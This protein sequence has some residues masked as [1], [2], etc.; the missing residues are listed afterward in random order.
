MLES[1]EQLFECKLRPL[2]LFPMTLDQRPPPGA[3]ADE[4]YGAERHEQR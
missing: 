1:V 3:H 4:R 2:R